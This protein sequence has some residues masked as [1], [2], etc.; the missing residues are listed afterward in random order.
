MHLDLIEFIEGAG[1]TKVLIAA[2]ALTSLIA[3]IDYF[4]ARDFSLGILYVFPVAICAATF[5]RRWA[6]LGAAATAALLCEELGTTPWQA[7]ATARIAMGLI[8]FSG[9]GLLVAKVVRTRRSEAENIRK[10]QEENTL[11]REA[12]EGARALVESS[13]AAIITVGPDGRIDLMN[14]AAKSML[15]LGSKPAT[16]HEIGDYF[17]VLG[18]LM[19]STQIGPT[20]TSM[21]ETSGR[22][23]NG[24]MFFAQ[25]WVSLFKTPA[26]MRLTAVIA[27]ASDQLR[28]REELGLRQLLMN[29]RIIAGAVS[30]EIRNLA[31]AAEALHGRVGQT[32]EVADDADF[33]ALGKLILALRKLSATEIPTDAEQALRGVDVSA[34]MRELRI[35]LGSANEGSAVKLTWEIEDNLPRVRADHSG[36]LQVLLNLTQNSIRAL[37]EQPNQRISVTAYRLNESVVIR[38]ADNGPGVSA[39]EHLFQPFQ[40]GATSAGLGLYV[41]RAIIRT[42]GG[43]MQYSRRAGESVFLIEL[44]AAVA[45]ISACV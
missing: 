7:D 17:P 25:M 37:G 42:Y 19:K 23:R 43:E 14:D 2:V 45:G 20:P 11:R 9:I 6:I 3:A 16:D 22:R 21:V 40:T 1:R 30:H 34:L 29:S 26:G 33:Q 10:L 24:E 8:G 15:G 13:P 12:E 41:S 39:A 28:D 35:I 18:N 4:L 31:A 44:P 38:V 36:L 5:P 32:R 27:D